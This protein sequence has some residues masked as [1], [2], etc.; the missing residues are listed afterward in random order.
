[1][2]NWYGC[3][4]ITVMCMPVTVAN[5]GPGGLEKLYKNGFV[6]NH[7]FIASLKCLGYHTT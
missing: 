4:S 1:M 3:M 7:A 5:V 6:N 2:H